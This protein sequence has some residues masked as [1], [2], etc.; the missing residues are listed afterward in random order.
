MGDL[1]K[2]NNYKKQVDNVD[3]SNVEKS[4]LVLASEHAFFLYNNQNIIK[5]TFISEIN[6]KVSL[7]GSLWYF[8]KTGSNG[9]MNLV[10]SRNKLNFKIRKSQN[11]AKLS[12]GISPVVVSKKINFK[13]RQI[14]NI[15]IVSIDK[16]ARAGRKRK[17]TEILDTLLIKALQSYDK[18]TILNLLD[19]DIRSKYMT[20]KINNYKGYMYE[21]YIRNLLFSPGIKND[22]QNIFL[23]CHNLNSAKK[24]LI[25]GK[26][27]SLLGIVNLLEIN[28]WSEVKGK[29]IYVS[30]KFDNIVH[31][32]SATHFLFKFKT[33]F[34]T[35]ILEFKVELIHD[36]AK[37]IEFNDSEDKVPAIDLEID[38]LK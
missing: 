21:V 18:Y 12:F 33:S 19:I 4:D 22:T 36:K 35:E 6:K 20:E 10:N 38:I 27:Y 37:Q 2:F 23:T 8:V 34:P 24:A 11:L 31:I 28:N 13:S 32:E 25:N 14:N 3:P 1:E 15:L 29:S 30:V 9:R 5:E 7:M 16:K 17:M 26:L